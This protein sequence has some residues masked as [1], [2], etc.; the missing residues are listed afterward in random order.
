MQIHLPFRA[1]ARQ[2]A[3]ILVAFAFAFTTRAIAQGNTN[4]TILGTVSDSGGA[5]VP[6]ASIQVKNVGTGQLQQVVTDGQGRYTVPDL[7]VG[8]YEA[9]ASAQGFQT[10][11][12]RGITLTVGQ[13]AVVDFSLQVGQSQQTVTVQADVSQVD[14][15]STAVSSYVEQKQINDLPL[16]GRNFT[17]LVTLVPGVAGGTQIGQGAANLLYGTENNFSVSGARSEGQAYLLDS[18]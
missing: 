17:D 11:V 9:Q 6:N 12:R 1:H 13:Q 16:N 5:V 10:T 7:P 14:T 3:A 4:A 18:T 15:V 2:W 8:S